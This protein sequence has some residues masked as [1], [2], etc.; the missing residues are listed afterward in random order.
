MNRNKLKK[1]VVDISISVLRAI[2]GPLRLGNF[3]WDILWQFGTSR[4]VRSTV[5]VPILGYLI[6]F[7]AELIDYWRTTFDVATD[8]VVHW[9]LYFLYF[10]FSSLAVGSL[11]F[12]VQCPDVVKEHGAAYNFVQREGPIM[13]E[14]RLQFMISMLNASR[15]GYT[16]PDRN[17]VMRDWFELMEESHP[18][19]R[20]ATTIAYGIGIFLLSIPTVHTFYRV[21]V[22]FA[23]GS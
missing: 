11:V 20:A 8:A 12:S 13:H 4:L 7:N 22:A 14:G 3:T 17:D 16:A 10:G 21:V 6:L 23:A 9:R 18:K 15:E 5:A 19:S 1:R 2:P